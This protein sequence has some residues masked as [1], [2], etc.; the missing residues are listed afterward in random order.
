MRQAVFPLI[1]VLVLTAGSTDAQRRV[2]S[3][4]LIADTTVVRLIAPGVIRELDDA[5]ARRLSDPVPRP[6]T[7]TVP[8]STAPAWRALVAGLSSLLRA[9]TVEPSD[10]AH[11]YLHIEPAQMRGDTLVAHFVI[12]VRWRC[13]SE[14]AGGYTTFEI[15]TVRHGSSWEGLR[16]RPRAHG[17][18]AC[19]VPPRSPG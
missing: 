9:R 14:W 6:W 8:D 16:S 7:I 15:T 18:G 11:S 3:H 19:L 12:G 10:S 13:G 5:L 2:G 4:A 1:A 17:H